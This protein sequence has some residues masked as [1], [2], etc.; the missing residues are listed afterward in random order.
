[1]VIRLLGSSI[2]MCLGPTTHAHTRARTY[3]DDLVRLALAGARLE[4]KTLGLLVAV[5]LP[6]QFALHDHVLEARLL[7]GH[8]LCVL[9]GGGTR[10]R[11]LI[12]IGPNVQHLVG[13][14]GP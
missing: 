3:L 1:M 14:A 11:H 9:F 12:E 5:L 4:L 10:E 6:L 13:S 7:R 2:C 8:I